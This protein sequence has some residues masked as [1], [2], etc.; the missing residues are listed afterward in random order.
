M[1]AVRTGTRL[2]PVRRRAAVGARQSKS[3]SDT[4]FAARALA[5]ESRRCSAP[6]EQL[7]LLDRALELHPGSLRT[8]CERAR[9]L[10]DVGDVRQAVLEWEGVLQASLDRSEANPIRARAARELAALSCGCGDTDRAMQLHQQAVRL[11]LQQQRS[12]SGR[13]LLNAAALAALETATLPRE[14][15]LRAVARTGSR[16]ERSDA[17]LQLGRLAVGQGD[18]DQAL[19]CFRRSAR[20]AAGPRVR[21]EALTWYGCLL[22]RTGRLPQ[23]E[24]TLRR[25]AGCL[26]RANDHAGAKRLFRLIRRIRCSLAERRRFTGRN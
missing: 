3:Q 9:C 15:L 22:A 14:R 23:A 1:P 4:Y 26:N 7:R 8:R 11:E 2:V 5:L 6:L 21:G 25:A 16:R 12:L 24:L 17:W 10:A 13:T 19:R 18:L 20:A